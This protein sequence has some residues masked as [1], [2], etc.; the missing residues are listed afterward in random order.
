MIFLILIYYHRGFLIFKKKNLYWTWLKRFW[1]KRFW[2][3]ECWLSSDRIL[4]DID[5][6]APPRLIWSENRVRSGLDT[7]IFLKP[8]GCCKPTRLGFTRKTRTG[9]DLP[10]TQTHPVPLF[11][12][13]AS[14]PSHSNPYTEPMTNSTHKCQ[15]PI[16]FYLNGNDPNFKYSKTSVKRLDGDHLS[17]DGGQQWPPISHNPARKREREKKLKQ[18]KR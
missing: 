8:L 16:Y 14:N 9:L 2:L 17:S 10:F 7:S 6:F 5:P 15:Q 18:I 3:E 1:V 12:L 4:Y 11:P 13:N